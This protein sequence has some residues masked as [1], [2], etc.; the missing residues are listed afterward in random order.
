MA[1]VTA[2]IRVSPQKKEKV[3]EK[4]NVRF[5]LRD[6]RKVQLFY[7]SSLEVN[8]C[9]WD[10]AKQEIKAKVVY[11]TVKRA[12]FNNSVATMK[13][14]ILEVYDSIRHKTDLTS[15]FLDIEVEK[16]LN[17]DKY[18]LS[19]SN[20]SFIET[21]NEFI[22]NRKISEVR[23]NNFRVISRALQRFEL[24][25]QSIGSKNF[26]L[27]FDDFSPELLGEVER[28]MRD[29]HKLYIK[30]PYIYTAVSESRTPQPR[31]QNTLN[32]ILTKIRTFFIWA[33]DQGKTKNNPFKT[34]KIEESTYGT[35]Y[36]ITIA[37]RNRLY[38]T[39]LSRHPKLAIQ[40]DIFVFQC[41]VGCRVGD[42]YRLTRK[43]RINGAVEYIARKTKD[44][45]PI[46]VR[47]PLNTIAKEI[48]E[49]YADYD[50]AKILPFISEQ[51]YNEAIKRMFL[52]ARLKRPVTIINPTTREPEIQPLNEI[53]SSHL[54][55]R[56]FVGNLYKQVKDPNLVG[57]LSG[58]KEGS[59]AFARYREIDEEIKNE[60]VKM[61]E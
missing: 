48:L 56:C 3:K 52:A 27:S 45:R 33:N 5:R 38:K 39:N 29:E 10:A 18:G 43:N 40:R 47:V 44:G 51:K 54:A 13:N 59:K 50:G 60:L 21:L 2:F 17:P 42:M 20:H 37:E 7:K 32:D 9:N 36:Y 24:Y 53:A 22:G 49:R 14:L 46:T 55:R 34:F 15:D 6:G 58:H 31:G 8:P 41:L 11:D 30:Y 19:E 35:P 12:E 28:F 57:V 23:K 1:T 61:L 4:V 16:H 26:K 25:K